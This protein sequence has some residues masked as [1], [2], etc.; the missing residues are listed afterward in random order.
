MCFFLAFLSVRWVWQRKRGHR[1]I[2]FTRR[3]SLHLIFKGLSRDT[4]RSR[5]HK[6]SGEILQYWQPE[7]CYL[8]CV[9]KYTFHNRHRFGP[10]SGSAFPAKRPFPFWD[11]F[12]NWDK[13]MINVS[14]I[15]HKWGYCTRALLWLCAG[16][17]AKCFAFL[18]QLNKSFKPRKDFLLSHGYYFQ[19]VPDTLGLQHIKIFKPECARHQRLEEENQFSILSRENME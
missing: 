16:R 9:F 6:H 11:R 7:S 1:G 18:Q 8:F 17:L 12:H 19:R 2:L 14:I 3:R 4:W 5:R 13:N 15:R 10:C